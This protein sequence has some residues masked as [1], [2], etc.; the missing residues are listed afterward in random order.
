MF[1]ALMSQ[2]ETAHCRSGEGFSHRNR[3]QRRLKVASIADLA[4]I[5][6]TL[7]R[8]EIAVPIHCRGK[9]GVCFALSMQALEWGLPIMSV[10]NKSYVPRNGGPAS[11]TKASCSHADRKREDAPLIGRLR[12]EILGAG[13]DRRCRVWGT[14]KGEREPHTYVSEPLSKMHPGHSTKEV[15]GT[16]MKFVK[17]SP[18]WDT[19][20]EVQMFYDASRDWARLFCPDV[21]LGAYSVEE[22]VLPEPIDVTPVTTQ[23]GALAQR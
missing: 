3:G 14:F 5:S 17:G 2:V 6:D 1:N 10:I 22:L 20:P 21:L 7:S 13:D 4:K 9:P 18:L 23:V 16:Q 19:K 12:F 8:G 15:N 11:D